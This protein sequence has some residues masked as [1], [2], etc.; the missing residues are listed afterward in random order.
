MRPA[1]VA[2][3]R[4]TLTQRTRRF[5]QRAQSGPG[6]V[7]PSAIS[8]SISAPSAVGWGGEAFT[9]DELGTVRAWLR[10]KSGTIAGG[11]WKLQLNIVSKPILGLPETT[12][13]G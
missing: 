12:Q 5:T 2:R 10:G 7:D 13:R 6:R 8:A 1:P 3:Q 9:R 4:R 11:S